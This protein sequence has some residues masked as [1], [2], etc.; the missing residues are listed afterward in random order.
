MSTPSYEIPP[1]PSSPSASGFV[2]SW[3]RVMSDPRSFFAD[4]AQA[5]GLQEP[6]AF[7]AVCAAVDAVG[8]LLTGWGIRGMLGTFLTV[9]AGGFVAAAVLTLVAQHLFEGRAGFEPMFRVVAYAAAPIVFLW[10]PRLWVIPLLYSWYLQIRGVER[11]QEF[12][13]TRALLTVAVKTAVLCVLV[14]GLRDWHL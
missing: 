8:M 10:V 3:R 12:D 9:V 6:L 14:V 2:D 13:A 7:L 11:V 1:P 5:G 4:M